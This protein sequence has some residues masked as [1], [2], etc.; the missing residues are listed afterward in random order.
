MEAATVTEIHSD[1]GQLFEV[2]IKD[3]R[4]K[5][6]SFDLPLTDD[7]YPP[8][9]ELLLA[10]RVRLDD[11]NFQVKNGNLVQVFRPVELPKV[12]FA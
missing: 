5:V 7:P 6:V 3:H 12:T 2:P 9:T 8:G 10:V 1:Q 4:A 11:D